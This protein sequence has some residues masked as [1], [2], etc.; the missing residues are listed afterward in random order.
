MERK[1]IY[2]T[3]FF[4][5]AVFG[6]S[7][8]ISMIS[9]TITDQTT[10]EPIAYANI[11]IE[12]TYT[13]GASDM[14]GNFEFKVPAGN[15]G[16]FI[17]ASAVGY[18]G[19]RIPLSELKDG[20][21][22]LEMVPT[23]YDIGVIDVSAQSLVLY[24][25]I[26]NAI[27]A[28]GKNYLKGP[29]SEKAYYKSET[30]VNGE[31]PRVNE[32]I[33]EISDSKGYQRESAFQ[34]QK[35]RNYKFLGVRRNFEIKDLAD[36]MNLMDDLLGFDIIRSQ[37]NILDESFLTG[38]D[39]SLDKVTQ[40]EGDSAWVIN[41]RLKEP[42]L[43]RTGDFYV[44]SYEGK[45]YIAKSNYAILKNETWVKASDVSRLGRNFANTGE[46]KWIPVSIGYEF[47]SVYRKVRNGYNLTYL[48]CNRHNV[49]KD[50][51]SG[52]QRSEVTTNHL[53]PTEVNITGPSLL[54]GRTYFT[55][56]PYD[57]GFWDGFSLIVD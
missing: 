5:M 30:T 28:I 55:D 14:S 39:L 1:I 54:T 33:V 3:I 42:D 27:D 52:E 23:S 38:Y 15:T 32:A 51:V 26:R 47:S 43:S 37:G 50:N 48:K 49:W 12:G 4:L 29:F 17:L 2:T 56:M 7:Q 13:G 35:H 11:G 6:Y 34:A 18:Q 44:T 22:H 20:Q 41:Y 24:R 36:G 10:K 40:F 9:G 53:I 31:P 25:T 19:I 8:P 57:A 45:I 16:T 21:L 46:R